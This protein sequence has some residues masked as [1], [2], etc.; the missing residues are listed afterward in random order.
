M[1]GELDTCGCCAAP[2]A[3]V[4]DNRP[5]QPAIRFRLGSHA[6]FLAD[7]KA[8]IARA[9]PALTTRAAEDPSI[10]MMDAA[11]VVCDILCFY[12]ERIAN[13][14]YLRTALERRSALWLARAIGYE[15]NPGVAAGTWLAFTI[16]DPPQVPPIPLIP[17]VPLPPP[18]IVLPTAITI[19]QGTKVQSIPG[20]GELPQT[21][22]TLEDIE[23]RTAW[24]A[25][26]PRRFQRQQLSVESGA[27]A[28]RDPTG[29]PSSVPCGSLW[30]AGTATGLKAGDLLV[31]HVTD[32]NVDPS[33]PVSSGQVRGIAIATVAAITAD[34]VNQMTRVDL[35]AGGETARFGHPDRADA[36]IDTS[37]IPLDA[38]SARTRVLEMEWDEADLAAFVAIQRWDEKTLTDQVA[39][40][41]A[42]APAAAAVYV[43][44]QRV[45]VFGCSAPA[46]QSLPEEGNWP[47][48]DG[49]GVSVWEDSSG[50]TYTQDDLY[51]ERS[52]SG[53]LAG[54]LVGLARPGD[55]APTL[56]ALRAAS[57]VSLADFAIAGKASALQLNEQSDQSRPLDEWTT[58]I[59]SKDETFKMRTTA[60]FTQSEALALASAPIEDPVADP[61]VDADGGVSWTPTSTVMLDRMVP[62]LGAGRVI[63]LSGPTVDADGAATGSAAGELATLERATHTGGYTVLQFAARLV[64]RYD[65]Q[66]LLLS[67]NVA[68]ASHGETQPVVPLA[69]SQAVRL[70][71]ASQEEILGSGDGAICNQTFMLSK[72]PLTFVSAATPSGGQSTLTVRVNGVAWNEVPS[73]YGQSSTARVY[74][75]R[76]DDDGT[77]WVTFGDGVAGARLPTGQDNVT[78]TYRSG[79]GTAGEVGAARLT[80]LA[81]RPPFVKYVSNPVAASGSQDAEDL[82]QARSNAPRTV[83]TLDRIVSLADYQDF[84]SSFAGVGKA[85]AL[86][87][88]SGRTRI[89]HITVASATGEALDPLS[90]TYGNLLDGIAAAADPSQSVQVDSFAPRFFK[91]DAAVFC[92][93]EYDSDQVLAGVQEALEDA[94]SFERRSFA[95][96]V[97]AAEI[98][99]FAHGVEGVLAIRI[100]AL[101]QAEQ[102][103]PTA[104]GVLAAAPAR[105]DAASRAVLPAELLLLQPAGLTLSAVTS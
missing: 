97:T 59:A 46:S 90:D 89:V 83:R 82:E 49:N 101:Y 25:M 86:A 81:S 19:P 68:R 56:F 41:L 84:A 11:A 58:R 105:F 92:R 85:Q 15:L 7:M 87:I 74:T 33:D 79:I 88:W 35:A 103:T 16:E 48:F 77:S 22:E 28:L 20:E 17:G 94:F 36:V 52:V 5:G 55:G 30:L 43:F 38:D 26:R 60:I 63:A 80:L 54:G 76:I 99:G 69:G 64:N 12:Q 9:L 47:D 102:S 71:G 93:P 91:L 65:R 62:G 34:D 61:V 95:Q 1:S 44:R 67:A 104:S 53:L 4:V 100:A 39:S 10:A 24:N 18:P 6:S 8:S 37:A 31:V 3:P 66:N 50:N 14:G 23:A 96:P 75:L 45:G 51:L 13:E 42:Q 57:E 29:A 2:E 98:I 40:L 78:A 73:L 72:S 27:L 70:P 21:F 32:D